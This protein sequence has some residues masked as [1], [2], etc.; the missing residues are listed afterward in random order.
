MYH[1]LRKGHASV[2]LQHE[3]TGHN[4]GADLFAAEFL[5][6]VATFRMRLRPVDENQ[7]NDE[8]YL[9]TSPLISATVNDSQVVPSFVKRANAQSDNVRSWQ[10]LMV[11]S[12]N[13]YSFAVH[14]SLEGFG[15]AQSLVFKVVS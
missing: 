10:L 9:A 1:S 13:T 4:I 7:K 6:G 2:Y 15:A 5:D 3:I 14:P 12:G 8:Q 11:C